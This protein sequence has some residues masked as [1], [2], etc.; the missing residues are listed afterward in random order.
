M[1][2]NT[3]LRFQSLMTKKI[4]ENYEKNTCHYWYEARSH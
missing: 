4:I 1:K 3:L 2:A